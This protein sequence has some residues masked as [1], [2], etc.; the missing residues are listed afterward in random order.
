MLDRQMVCLA[1]RLREVEELTRLF[2]DADEDIVQR[3][4][5]AAGR[6]SALEP[7]ADQELLA[8]AE[9]PLSGERAERVSEIDSM[10]AGAQHRLRLLLLRVLELAEIHD[11]T[12]RRLRQ[13]RY[14]NQIQ[15]SFIR[16]TQCF[17][18]SHNPEGFFFGSNE[19]HLRCGN[20]L[21]QALRFILC[22]CCL[23]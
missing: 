15:L 21:I 12:H 10:L 18:D 9:A 5:P 22:Y 2:V 3:A 14:L 13:R 17:R 8:L 16:Q 19:A 4:V 20:H 11:A 1:R 6:L 7:C 23:R